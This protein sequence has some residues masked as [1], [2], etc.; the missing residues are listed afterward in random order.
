MNI[1]K[2]L[3]PNEWKSSTFDIDYSDY[4]NSGFRGI[5]FDIDNTLVPHGK[6]GDEE[7]ASFINGL[8]NI[9]FKIMLV[10]NNSRER[11]QKF[12]SPLGL[13]YIYKAGKPSV[14]GYQEASRRLN[15]S[16]DRMLCIGDQ[17]FT[18][19]WGGNRA[20]M[21]TILVNPIDPSE[22]IQIILKRKLEKPVLMLYKKQLDKLEIDY[23]DHRRPEG[24]AK[25]VNNLGE[26][27]RSHRNR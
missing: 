10:S 11:N 21:H 5:I 23:P 17:L 15:V 26:K 22:E 13:D 12:A 24:R 2:G 8:K 3:F 20:G 14:K 16:A 1:G 18:D 25:I 6:M 9:G 4:F 19:I 7:L 27:G